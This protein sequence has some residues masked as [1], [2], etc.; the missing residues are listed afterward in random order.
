MESAFRLP[1]LVLLTSFLTVSLCAA[2]PDSE[3]SSPSVRYL[4]APIA[5]EANHGQADSPVA[6][7]SHGAGY[8]LLLQPRQVIL[9]VNR[10]D[11]S[12]DSQAWIR[13]TFIGANSK[14]TLSGEQKLPGVSNYLIG[15]DRSRW[16]TNIPNFARVQYRDIYRGINLLYY[17]NQKHLEYDFQVSPHADPNS[18]RFSISGARPRLAA[19]GDLLL[20][21]KAGQIAWRK[22][23]A[24]QLIAGEKR[25]VPCSYAI[26]GSQVRF[27]L[28]AYDHNRTLVID[29]PLV[30]GSFLGGS[31]YD[32]LSAGVRVDPAGEL[33]VA[34]TT[35]SSN[36]PTTSGA[37]GRSLHNPSDP[38][39]LDV[40][41]SKFSPNG[42]S[43]VYSTYVGGSGQDNA[44]GLAV[45]ADGN[46][47]VSGST[48]SPD[49]PYTSG[50][51]RAP[52]T[53]NFLFKL[54]ATGTNLIYSLAALTNGGLAVDSSGAAYN[55][56]SWSVGTIAY[57]FTRGAYHN[58]LVQGKSYIS[59]AKYNSAGTALDYAALIGSAG[60][61]YGRGI[62]VDSLGEATLT[63]LNYS[64]GYTGVKYPVTSGEPAGNGDDTIVTK[65][66]ASGTALVYSALLNGSEGWGVSTDATGNVAVVGTASPA[67]PTTKNAYEPTF[68]ASGIGI[69]VAFMTRLDPTGHVTY[70]TFLG[71]S[72]P[73]QVYEYAFSTAVEPGGVINVVG[74]KHSTNFPI[75]DSTYLTPDCLWLAR[76][77]PAASGKA[78]LLY[79]GCV[80]TN[81][82]PNQPLVYASVAVNGNGQV[83]LGMQ[84]TGPTLLTAPQPYSNFG[85]A[86]QTFAVEVWLGYLNFAKPPAPQPIVV[87]LPP[88]G[89]ITTLPLHYVAT[90]ST[91]C[92]KGV[93]AI[94]VYTS[95]GVLKYSQTGPH[96]DTTLA[97][98]P[99]NYHTIVQAWDNCGGYAKTPISVSVPPGGISVSSPTNNSTV[100]SPVHFVA[101]ATS[102]TC[103][104]G[105]SGMVIY[106][107][108]GVP[109]YSTY[110]SSINA[111]VALNS[112][113][114][115]VVIQA[116]DNCNNIFQAPLTI[117]VK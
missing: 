106:S 72:P 37:F 33:V 116:W 4:N 3:T 63:G 101:T 31:S 82:N 24:Y 84:D 32:T 53:S 90:A 104:N 78:S 57:P 70:S 26:S 21:T 100:S 42:T 48:A 19:N 111:N 11:A 97:L 85:P 5:F 47:Y 80:S 9:S 114:Y 6:F 96:L 34:G 51:Y 22:P 36:F 79:S 12:R 86:G 44:F 115:N 71:G 103:P 81:V 56:G 45:D 40:F 10:P 99:G 27:A 7:L 52:V 87:N 18:I 94:G 113:T 14:S 30:W 66:N 117:T 105:F 46:A 67:L 92:S 25:E 43:L 112:G 49:F 59:V 93:S 62:A 61:N 16:L 102:P 8:S 28:A 69:H 55:V 35:N 23:V 13:T 108:P 83:Y 2:T 54:D 98:P 91:S 64:I 107:S 73:N 89:Q 76:F 74:N 15:A 110:S 20:V 68:P 77:N 17:G 38:N 58:Q 95:P 75:T 41:V 88:N 60:V 29:P 109:A 39:A 50:S 1:L 65:F